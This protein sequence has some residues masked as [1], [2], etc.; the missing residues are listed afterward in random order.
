MLLPML[1]DC[2]ALF[3]EPPDGQRN[4]SD[5]RFDSVQEPIVARDASPTAGRGAEEL[6]EEVSRNEEAI[7]LNA[8]V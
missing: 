7:C 6:S 3:R 4:Q 5:E 2:R 8:W 1:D